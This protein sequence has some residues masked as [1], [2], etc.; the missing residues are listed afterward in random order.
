MSYITN[1]TIT[2]NMNTAPLGSKENPDPNIPVCKK[3]IKGRFYIRDGILRKWDGHVLLNY[4][5]SLQYQRN[6]YEK[7]KEKRRRKQKIYEEK[8]KDRISAQKKEYRENLSP[9]KKEKR[10]KSQNEWREKNWEHIKRYK[11]EWFKNKRQTDPLWTMHQN[12][13]GQLR[14]VLTKN[15]IEKNERSMT[16]CGCT[17]SEFYRHLEKQFTDGMNWDNRGKPK[18]EDC[19]WD[20]E[21]R[22]PLASFDWDNPESI[23]MAFHY[24]NLQPMWHY[25]NL[26]KGDDYDPVT[27]PYKWVD[28]EI[29]WIKK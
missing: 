18:N 2:M 20:I 23:F 19:G 9:E 28:R 7:N 17:V 1:I 25:D 5:K 13:R 14:S 21:H 11:R 10:K 8:N 3:R 4:A 24:T 15:N 16:Y 22:R 27:F 6:H 12:L 29:G 26:L